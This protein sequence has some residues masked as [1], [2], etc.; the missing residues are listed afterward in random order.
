M[1]IWKIF[2]WPKYRAR[3]TLS[4]NSR[5]WNGLSSETPC[6]FLWLMRF[7]WIWGDV[8]LAPGSGPECG[9]LCGAAA[10]SAQWHNQNYCLDN[11][12]LWGAGGLNRTQNTHAAAPARI[13]IIDH[14][15]I[16]SKNF[17][18]WFLLAENRIKIIRLLC[19]PLELVDETVRIHDKCG[20]SDRIFELR[21]WAPPQRPGIRAAAHKS[22]FFARIREPTKD[23]R[24][25]LKYP[26]FI[27][28]YF[29]LSTNDSVRVGRRERIPEN[30]GPPSQLEQFGWNFTVRPR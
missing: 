3:S 7:V 13:C 28:D 10:L 1:L 21:Q 17:E 6:L 29:L 2:A 27:L 23:C 19:E 22:S 9:A 15:G 12:W 16:K 5:L 20:D 8:R 18:N 26:S 14:T 25:W 30:P 24:F 11:I 4:Q